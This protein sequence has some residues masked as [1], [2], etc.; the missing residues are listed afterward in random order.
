MKRRHAQLLAAGRDVLRGQHGGVGR[1]LVAI[2]LDLHAACD[3]DEG[4]A[5]REVGH[6]YE[7]VVEGR[8]KVCD[9]EDLLALDEVGN[10][11]NLGDRFAV[12]RVGMLMV[13]SREGR[14]REK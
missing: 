3:P 1:A 14:G 12:C 7:G 2:G 8:E 9:G 4:L 13:R 5:T 10:L 6:M 11:G